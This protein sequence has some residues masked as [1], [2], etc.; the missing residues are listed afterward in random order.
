MARQ[1]QSLSII[2]GFHLAWWGVIIALVSLLSLI[3]LVYEL[4]VRIEPVWAVMIMIG[5]FGGRI[6][7]HKLNRSGRPGRSTHANRVTSY[8]WIGVGLAATFVTF[9]EG[10][11]YIDFGGRGYF[12]IF[13]MCGLGLI[14]TSAAGSE[15][16]LLLS[17]AGWFGTGC[18]S[19]F[20]PPAALV[21]YSITVISCLIFLVLPGLII[22]IRTRE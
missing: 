12:I 17:G 6:L 16:L 21:L 8:V 20:F 10:G 11:G 18:I 13:L 19:L 4:P 2:S 1:G 15:P 5:W 9:A 14:A 3:I 7:Q 22:G